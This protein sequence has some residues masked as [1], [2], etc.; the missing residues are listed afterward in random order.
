MGGLRHI[1]GRVEGEYR[2]RKCV[3]AHPLPP[4]YPPI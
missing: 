4:I 3:V 1:T 2:E